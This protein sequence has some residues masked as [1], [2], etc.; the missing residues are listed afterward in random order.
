M[1]TSPVPKAITMELVVRENVPRRR[2][3]RGNA[4]R[5]AVA[6]A[7]RRST[8]ATARKSQVPVASR[9]R[10]RARSRNRLK[11][12]R[13]SFL[14]SSAS[15][16]F[17]RRR[18]PPANPSLTASAARAEVE[19]GVEIAVVA[20]VAVPLEAAV[21]ARLAASAAGAEVDLDL[22]VTVMKQLSGS[23]PGI[24][25]NLAGNRIDLGPVLA[26]SRVPVQDL[27][28]SPDL[29]RGLAPSRDPVRDRAQSP[30][31]ARDPARRR[32]QDP[33]LALAADPSPNPVADQGPR[34]NNA[35]LNRVKSLLTIFRVVFESCKK[36]LIKTN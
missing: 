26:P 4:K 5:A 21:I 14:P 31:P 16:C 19:A 28:P 29:D 27:D 35:P 33:A 9:E 32:V 13:R 20:E 6:S 30:V 24:A 12:P 8:R 1:T 2:R 7:K 17:P 23:A 18:S 15:R 10:R 11:S 25:S 34:K 22:G 3:A 36:I